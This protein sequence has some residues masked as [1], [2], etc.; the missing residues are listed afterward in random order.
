VRRLALC[1]VI[2]AISIIIIPESTHAQTTNPFS[3]PF[4]THPSPQTWMLGQQ[5]GNTTGAYNYGRYWYASGQGLHFGIDFP[6][7][8][9]TA[10]IAVADGVVDYVDN[11]VFGLQPHN[12]VLLHENGYTTI[13]GHLLSKPPLKKG[14]AVRR[15]DVIAMTGDPDHTCVSRPHLHFEVRTRDHNMSLNP[16][17]FIDADWSMLSSIGYYVFNG[18]VKDLSNPRHWQTPETQPDVKF[19]GPILNRYQ[20]VWP[21]SIRVQP[22]TETLPVVMAPA[23]TQGKLATLKDLTEPDCCSQPYW[24]PDSKHVWFID[25]EAAQKASVMAIEVESGSLEI[26]DTMPPARWSADGTHR[27]KWDDTLTTVE[28]LT[29]L[30][31]FTVRSGAWP[32]FSPNSAWMMWQYLPSDPVPGSSVPNT[33]IWLAQPDGKKLQMIMQPRA[34]SVYW[35]DDD[36]ILVLARKTN[37]NRST[38]KIYT[39]S[40]GIQTD[41]W[42]AENLR[43][44]SVAPG[45][46]YIMFY[47]PFQEEPENSAILILETQSGAQPVKLPFFGSW[48]WRDSNSVIYIPFTPG[49]PMKFVY[50]DVIDGESQDLTD[51]DEQHFSIVNDDWAVSPDGCYIV[52]WQKPTD[53]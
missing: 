13:Y 25:G 52:M 5:F 37:T 18:F 47:T 22:P 27:L 23:I 48:K 32:T 7:P 43:G 8:C 24:S 40:T 6:A 39:I 53:N 33:E 41:L 4:N 49:K 30:S 29:D 1:V 45:G 50:Y 16:V 10:V 44:L 3:L 21:V 11:F 19:G 36:R 42:E 28:R 14:Q 26:A 20:D 35:L 38:L 15:G 2:C 31:T 51:P 9:G 17:N 46:R 12:I 34:G